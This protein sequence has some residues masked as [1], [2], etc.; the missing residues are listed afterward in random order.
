M[1]DGL[2][3]ELS[4]SQSYRHLKL[5][6]QSFVWVVKERQYDRAEEIGSGMEATMMTTPGTTNGM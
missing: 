4:F 1:I 2:S 5:A 6:E 3:V